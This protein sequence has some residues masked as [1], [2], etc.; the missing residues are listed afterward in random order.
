M[1]ARNWFVTGA[2]S[3]IGYALVS[4][5]LARGDRVAAIAR[6]IDRLD[7]LAG[8]DGARLWRSSVDIT[9]SVAVRTAAAEAVSALGRIDVV[10][11]CAGHMLY[12][13]AEELSESEILNQ[14]A[15]NL[16]GSIHVIRSLLPHLRANRSGLIVQVSSEAGQSAYPG[17]SVYQ[18][19]KWGIEGFCEALAL[20]TTS[21][22]VR[23]TIV[24]PGHVAT[25]LE[26]HAVTVQPREDVYRMG[27]VGNFLRLEAMGR[28]PRIGDPD[29][30][31][32]VIVS[33]AD[34]PAPP[35]RLTLGSD[36]YRNV[37]RALTRRMLELEL[38][39]DIATSTDFSES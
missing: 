2:S 3:G 27:P 30:V 7:D 25:D 20:E 22:N 24:E 18:A 36:G 14:I 16:L 1:T 19:T 12:G 32:A 29:K 4:R 31:A 33:L 15:T 39:K 26:K 35:L 38:Q 5:L 34:D 21:F 28:F 6:N 23:V 8:K 11:S 13:A 17:M 37:H 9:D 10:A